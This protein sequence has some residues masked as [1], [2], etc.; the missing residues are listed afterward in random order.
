MVDST[1]TG[2]W[3]DGSTWVGGVVPAEGEAVNI[4][5]GHTVTYNSDDNTTRYG[6]INVQAVGILT[7]SDTG[8]RTLKFYSLTQSGGIINVGSVGTPFNSSYTC[9]LKGDYT[10]FI[11]GNGSSGSDRCNFYGADKTYYKTTLNGAVSATDT[12]IT[13][14]DTTGWTIGDTIV[15]QATN[16]NDTCYKEFE[17]FKIKAISGTTVTL[18]EYDDDTTG[19][20]LVYGHASGAIV[21]N[22]NRNI[23]LEYDGALTT[24]QCLHDR[25]GIVTW[26]N[27]MIVNASYTSNASSLINDRNYI[28]MTNVSILPN[29]ADTGYCMYFGSTAY[30]NV[31]MDNCFIL[32]M[33][34]GFGWTRNDWM[35]TEQESPNYIQNCFFWGWS[36]TGDGSNDY[37]FTTGDQPTNITF[38]SCH[39]AGTSNRVLSINDLAS[40]LFKDCYI[41]ASGNK[42]VYQNTA[43]SEQNRK[44][45]LID[46]E[47]GYNQL[48]AC[49]CVGGLVSTGRYGGVAF[50]NCKFDSISSDTGW[51]EME[52]ARFTDFNQT[53]GDNRLYMKGGYIKDDTTTK[54]ATTN[55]LQFNPIAGST[56]YMCF[57]IPLHFTTTGSKTV[58]LR[59]KKSSTG[60][61]I[62][63]F[64]WAWR[65]RD[66]T[67]S[68]KAT[69]S[70]VDTNWN[71]KSVVISA[72]AGDTWLLHVQVAYDLSR[73]FN[74]DDLTV[75]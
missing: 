25:K 55:S 37:M 5:N 70:D 1:Q 60:Y 22:Y 23:I 67:R 18:G 8:N 4:K 56:R 30:L 24:A 69:F 9:T 16:D 54:Y 74:I 52:T 75:A 72:T 49:R 12:T 71:Q 41:Y 21:L 31:T 28:N 29:I 61:S 63:P 40:G 65:R 68:S 46:C 20:A 38:D 3:E 57:L 33:D 45:Y 35:S 47:M 58:S 48:G 64:M 19:D 27:V 44:T 59:G 62:H 51:G 15:I 6:I 43:I 42:A 2:N 11:S 13:T 53:S 50:I 26:K 34:V 14:T 36:S 10:N 39:F 17:R 7:I 66:D 73:T 32:T